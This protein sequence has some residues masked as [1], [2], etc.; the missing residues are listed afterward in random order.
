MSVTATV[1]TSLGCPWRA[2]TESFATPRCPTF[3][4]GMRARCSAFSKA[5]GSPAERGRRMSRTNI[6]FCK[7]L[8]QVSRFIF[9]ILALSV[10]APQCHLSQS[11][12]PWQSP[13]CFRFCQGLPLWE[14]FLPVGGKWQ[15]QKGEQLDANRR[16][17][18]ASC[19]NCFRSCTAPYS[20]PA[21][22]FC[23][24]RAHTGGRQCSAGQW[25]PRNHRRRSQ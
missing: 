11:E 17:E 9:S 12:R 13:Q 14:R 24:W 7:F 5:C 21:Q 4:R 23:R 25:P 10:I 8:L 1:Y 6:M 16:P 19:L 3:A 22:K 15:S 20:C 18:R 2:S